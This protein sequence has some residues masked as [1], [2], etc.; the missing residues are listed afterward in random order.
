MQQGCSIWLL[1]TALAFHG[2]QS[3]VS[4]LYAF[5]I[6]MNLMASM[7]L[8]KRVLWLASNAVTTFFDAISMC[9]SKLVV[10][11]KQPMPR[12]CGN[13]C[14]QLACYHANPF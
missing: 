13:L 2:R 6:L 5:G 12:Q 7:L 10:P 8:V 1:L 3:I 11:R 4:L 9:H 14:S